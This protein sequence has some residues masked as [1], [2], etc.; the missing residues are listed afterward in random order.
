[1]IFLSFQ[2]LRGK[3]L[4]VFYEELS[5]DF[6]AELLWVMVMEQESKTLLWLQLPHHPNFAHL[7]SVMM[8]MTDVA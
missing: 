7:Q 2:I 3:N 4:N 1:M 6:L 8:Y 5:W